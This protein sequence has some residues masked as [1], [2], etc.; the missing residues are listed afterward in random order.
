M[1]V[2]TIIVARTDANSAT[3]LTSDIDPRDHEYILDPTTE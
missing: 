1:G 3:L 2:P